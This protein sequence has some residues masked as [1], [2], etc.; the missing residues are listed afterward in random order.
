MKVTVRVEGAEEG[1]SAEIFVRELCLN[2][3]Y[4]MEKF[5]SIKITG[6]DDSASGIVHGIA[7][8]RPVPAM[9]Q[10]PAPPVAS[11]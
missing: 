8:V 7:I 1:V 6:D 4:R 2:A 10:P 11:D 3:G 5:S 9:P